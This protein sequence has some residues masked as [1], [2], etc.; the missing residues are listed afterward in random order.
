MNLRRVL[1]VAAIAA[2]SLAA[3]ALALDRIFP[4]EPEAARVVLGT[5]AVSMI[6]VVSV[7]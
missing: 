7:V 1:A 2:T 3:G 5:I 6:T 4:P